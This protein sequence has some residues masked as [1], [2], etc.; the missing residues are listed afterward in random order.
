TANTKDLDTSHIH[1]FL[2]PTDP[3][4]PPE[5]P[6]PG[7]PHAWIDAANTPPVYKLAL[8]WKV[9][10]PLHPEYRTLPMVWYIPPLSPIQSAIE[11][12]VIGEN[13]LIPDVN[14]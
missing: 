4:A 1:R 8:E 6:K 12:G 13:G 9:A 2:H 7:I 5:A 3:A 14:E 11:S 10:F